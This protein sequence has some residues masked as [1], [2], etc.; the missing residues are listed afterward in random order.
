VT[1]ASPQRT[2]WLVLGAVLAVTFTLVAGFQLVGLTVGTVN[3]D[4]HHVLSGNVKEVRIDG[5]FSDLEL[6]PSDGDQVVVDS[7]AEGSLWMPKVRTRIDGDRVSV[8]GN[9]HFVVLGSCGA[10]FVIHVPAGMPVTV[11]TGSGDVHASGLSGP[12]SLDVSSGDMELH[13]LTGGTTA[14]VQSGDIVADALSGRVSLRASSGDI[15]AGELRSREVTARSTSGDVSVDVAVAPDRVDASAS[16]GDVAVA[17][18]RG[19]SYDATVDT[20]SGDH[21]LGV[22]SDPASDRRVSAV[23]SSGDATIVYR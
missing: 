23:T 7:H 21:A 19:V 14:Q 8:S 18:P 13:G 3:K 16:S 12:V 1:T 4:E 10:R 9:C 6:A 2:L 11:S 22:A 20:S 5:A 15:S 17:V